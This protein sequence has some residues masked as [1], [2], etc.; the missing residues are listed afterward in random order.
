MTRAADP[1]LGFQNGA[2][3]PLLF[4]R[5]DLAGYRTALSHSE[6][7]IHLPQ[8]PVERRPGTR[9]VHDLTAFADGRGVRLIPFQF[10]RNDA[11]VLVMA[12]RRAMLLRGRGIVATANGAAPYVIDHPYDALEL[13]YL[14]WAQSGD[15]LFFAHQNHRPRALVR[16]GH[17]DWSWS[18]LRLDDGP[19]RPTNA[20][21]VTIAASAT[22]G[23]VT[24]TA[25]G[26]NVFTSDMVGTAIRIGGADDGGWAV[27]TAVT[28]A[29]SATA[30]VKK[31]FVDTDPTTNWRLAAWGTGGR[32]WPAAIAMIDNRLV[33]ARSQAQPQTVWATAVGGWSIDYADFDPAT[34]DDGGWG[35]TLASGRHD[36]I[37]WLATDAKGLL[38]G[39][40]SSLFAITGGQGSDAIT[41]KSVLAR[42]V[43][44][45]GAQ[46]VAPAALPSG[47]A[48]IERGG[49]RIR[50]A[51]W[52]WTQDTWA[53]IDLT[54]WRP[55]EDGVDVKALAVVGARETLLYALLSN[56]AMLCATI[57]QDQKILAWSDWTTQYGV[58]TAIAA[59]PTP[60]GRRD[61]LVLAVSRLGKLLLEIQP[62]RGEGVF[63]DS[64]SVSGA[65][66]G[67]DTLERFNGLTISCVADGYFVGTATPDGGVVTLPIPAQHSAAVGLPLISILRTMPA[68]DGVADGSGQ[69]GAALLRPK[70]VVRAMARFMAS[71]GGRM[72]AR[73]EG[74]DA[75]PWIDFPI[76]RIG[77]SAG[78]P[79]T[80]TVD[81]ALGGGW[82]RGGRI[83]IEQPH[84]YPMTIGFI[85]LFVETPER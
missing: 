78:A 45:V 36:R 83:E 74:D 3:S 61:D 9:F 65:A 27:I 69:P 32:V 51:G 58:V 22:T 53:A 5:A 73:E 62:P 1:I 42:P 67:V 60:D 77:G 25:S 16:R 26:G 72:R 52:D 19:Y 15:A 66:A 48:F 20:S 64:V 44:A 68:A 57:D 47:T 81:V 13:P 4:G 34:T 17:L 6:N 7:F 29:T 18:D 21:A 30:Q 56:G 70:R 49:G 11:Y 79:A 50:L 54:A 39:T 40:A 59:A 38:V 33:F 2:W 63:L 23:S 24:L 41:N 80:L 75:A 55:I 14:Q 12:H 46:L 76:D 71:M 43:A 31:A 10:S 37:L 85:Q 8:G 28:S 84:P 82:S 35:F